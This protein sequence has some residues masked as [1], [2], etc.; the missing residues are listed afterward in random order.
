MRLVASA[1]S[2]KK[3]GSH[4]PGVS[5]P[6]HSVPALCTLLTALDATL[7]DG[8]DRHFQSLFWLDQL[9]DRERIVTLE[10]RGKPFIGQV[11]YFVMTI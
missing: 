4:R 9:L 2:A 8:K 7:F 1:A 11:I 3:S 6:F 10:I 5:K